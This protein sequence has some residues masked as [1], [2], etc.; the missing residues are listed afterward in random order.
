MYETIYYE[1]MN[2]TIE[3]EC[4]NIN[5]IFGKTTAIK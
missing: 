5:G 1:L 4:G 2:R 3:R